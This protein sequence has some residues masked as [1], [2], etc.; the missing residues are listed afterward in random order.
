[1]ERFHNFTGL[2]VPH[3]SNNIDT[4]AIIPK[5]F[6]TSVTKTGYGLFLFNDTRW[7]N[8]AADSNTTATELKPNPDFVL[9][10]ERYR[11]AEILIT[12]EN[13]ACGSSREHA[14]WALTDYGFKAIIAQS[15]ADIFSSNSSKNGLLLISLP[16]TTIKELATS[17][18][19]K[20]GY[21]IKVM[22]SVDE[23]YVEASDKQH[24]FE[25]D[26]GVKERLLKGLDEIGITE[27]M[28]GKI[29]EYER[30]RLQVEPWLEID[31]RP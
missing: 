15:F 25:V 3:V 28:Q 21:S 12:G 5:Q 23:P 22:L 13:F 20:E 27:R 29:K 11:D 7:L 19:A 16:A 1:M 18:Q 17:C 26:P 30:Q 6:L 10:Q 2:A 8:P 31:A 24:P 9:N 14:V 4:D